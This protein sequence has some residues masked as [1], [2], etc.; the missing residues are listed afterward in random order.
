MFSAHIRPSKTALLH[1]DMYISLIHAFALRYEDELREQQQRQQ[2]DGGVAAA[3]REEEEE[4]TRRIEEEEEARRIEEEEEA[5]RIEEEEARRSEEL[6]RREQ[7]LLRRRE[8]H[9]R[10]RREAEEQMRLLAEEEEEMD[11]QTVSLRSEQEDSPARPS[12]KRRR[13]PSR[14]RRV[15]AADSPH[16]SRDRKSTPSSSRTGAGSK[17]K[18]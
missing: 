18:K 7:D 5:R 6:Q 9:A 11:R 13:S 3:R 4:E 15:E 12:G 10:R 2:G 16:S 17:R 8:E 1:R 14:G